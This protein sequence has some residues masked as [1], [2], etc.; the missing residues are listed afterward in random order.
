MFNWQTIHE[1]ITSFPCQHFVTNKQ[2][3]NNFFVIYFYCREMYNVTLPVLGNVQQ[4]LVCGDHVWWT[5]ERVRQFC[6]KPQKGGVQRTLQ[7]HIPIL[8]VCKQKC[9]VREGRTGWVNE[10]LTCSSNSFSSITGLSWVTSDIAP[11][12][13]WLWYQVTSAVGSMYLKK[14]RQAQQLGFTQSDTL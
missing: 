12:A 13:P 4:N 3:K 6:S 7:R 2:T 8:T 5:V 10:L 1:I 11:W 14:T 9:T